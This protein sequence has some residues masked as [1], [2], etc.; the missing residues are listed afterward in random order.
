MEFQRQRNKNVD[1]AI[2]IVFLTTSPEHHPKVICKWGL[3]LSHLPVFNSASTRIG[4]T[5]HRRD[6]QKG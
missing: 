1:R 4:D 3:I 2:E 6:C 5:G